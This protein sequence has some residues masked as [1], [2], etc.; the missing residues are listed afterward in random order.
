M[1]HN[2]MRTKTGGQKGKEKN[3]NHSFDCCS[4]CE[5]EKKKN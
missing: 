1:S 3:V 5:K 4:L 2:A